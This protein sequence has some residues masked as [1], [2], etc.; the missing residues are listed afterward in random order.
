MVEL[1]IVSHSWPVYVDWDRWVF[2]DS[3]R[4]GTLLTNMNPADWWHGQGFKEEFAKWDYHPVYP[5]Q[6]YYLDGNDTVNVFW[7][8]VGDSQSVQLFIPEVIPEIDRFTIH[9]NPA[10]DYFF[11]DV[12]DDFGELKSLDIFSIEGK[13]LYQNYFARA[14][15]GFLPKGVYLVTLY[16]S[17]Q[18][19]L[20]TKLIK[21]N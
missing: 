4:N 12:P 3:C 17:K 21:A 2:Q 11:V 14:D 5:N 16:N 1:D 15:I 10:S 20:R 19:A 7:L 13:L 8:A 9:P 18:K 6:W